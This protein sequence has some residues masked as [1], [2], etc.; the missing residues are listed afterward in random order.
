M[1]EK[2]DTTSA[3]LAFYDG[4]HGLSVVKTPT[5]VGEMIEPSGC[6]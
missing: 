1:I 2:S 5:Q 4:P 3:P 6:Q